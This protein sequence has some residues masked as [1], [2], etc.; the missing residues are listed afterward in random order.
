MKI[1]EIAARTILTRTG[2]GGIDYCLNPYTGC[3]H[4]C[5]Y[6]YATFMRKYSGHEEPWGE[7]VDAKMNAPELLK[8]ELRRR[9]EGE[10]ILS[11]VTD[12]YQPLEARFKLTRACLELLS[13]SDLAVS[14]LTKSA[15]VTRDL[16]IFR[17]IGTLEVG[18]T[19]TTDREDV[20]GIFEPH[21]SSIAARLEALQTLK[22]AGI[23]THAFIGPLLPMDPAKLAE[24]LAP[25]IEC[26][27]IDRM[28]YPWKV[29]ELYRRH[30][31]MEAL[32][33]PYFNDTA[34]ALTH[35]LTSRGVGVEVVY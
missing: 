22:Q 13:L 1:S 34:E 23:R 11:S 2:I 9:R 29:R 19:V 8:R 20:R 32:D 4:G 28:N 6:C 26:A 21:A 24:A 16:D 12:P 31:I 18:L 15:L 25:H 7:F 35:E 33:E 14:I 5:L 27:M 10:V 3:G 17:R 30:G